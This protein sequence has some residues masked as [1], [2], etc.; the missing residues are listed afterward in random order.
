MEHLLLKAATTATDEGTFEAVISTASV[1]RDGD[2]VEPTAIAKALS[3]WAALGK[4][5]PLAYSH[6]DPATGQAVVVGHIV[7]DSVR[8]EGKEVISKGW[9]DQATE[10]GAETWRLV[11]SGTLSFSY[12]YLIPKGGATKRLGKNTGLHITEID[13][14]EVSVVPVG[15][16]NNDTRV[17]SFKAMGPD[18]VAERVRAMADELA[19]DDPPDPK[20]MADRMRAMAADLAA[21]SKS[22]ETLDERAKHVAREFEESLIPAV[23]EQPKAPEIDPVKELQEYKAQL[24]QLREDL[25]ALKK[26][27]EEADKEPPAARSVDP[28]RKQ[29]EAVALEFASDGQSLLKPPRT[30]EPPK[31]EPELSLKDLKQRMRDELLTHLNGDH[32]E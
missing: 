1:D 2:I 4:L 8:V 31:R 21:A 17:L 12:G 19:S 30:V 22:A 26:K 28:L 9:V 27:T 24:T 13:L 20:D 7:P 14:Y 29:A 3:K 16:A 6:R 25:D 18:R 5:M 10:R 23:P 32:S 11:K 15:P